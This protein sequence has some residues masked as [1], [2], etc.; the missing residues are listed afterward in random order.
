[1]ITLRIDNH[2]VVFLQFSYFFKARPTNYFMPKW[3]TIKRPVS[4]KA[5]G[6]KTHTSRVHLHFMIYES[7]T[8]NL[9][10]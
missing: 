8:D 10:Q 7:L 6:L 5:R 4:K 1:M 3:K 9:S 2:S